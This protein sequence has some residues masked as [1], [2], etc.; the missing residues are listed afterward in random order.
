MTR[1]SPHHRGETL[2]AVI[3]AANI[4]RDAELPLDVPGVAETFPD[5]LS[6][7]GAL[8]LTW[9]TRLAGQIERELMSQPLD[10][11][12]AVE[13]AW[14]RTF[15]ELRGVRLVLDR[16][17]AEPLDDAMATAMTKAAGKEHA[18]LAAMAGQAGV[19]DPGAGAVGA[20][21]EERA[22]AASLRV[23]ELP[24][25]VPRASILHRLRSALAA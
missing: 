25:E 23:P 17:R 10:L 5:E 13:V 6:L 19:H 15:D 22:R 11:P 2:R 4:R 8:Q 12:R 21:I 14:G 3:A 7:L 16:Y 9:H 20:R 24:V 18:L 1:T